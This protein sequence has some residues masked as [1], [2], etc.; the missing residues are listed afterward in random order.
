MRFLDQQVF[1]LMASS[2]ALVAPVVFRLIG[3]PLWRIGR[4]RGYVTQVQYFRERFE[5]GALGALLFAVLA[6]L[7]VV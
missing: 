1:G 6:L 7:L 2:S 5:S 4:R 3:V